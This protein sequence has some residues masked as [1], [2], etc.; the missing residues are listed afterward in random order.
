MKNIGKGR[1]RE[2]VLDMMI[3]GH[4]TSEDQTKGLIEKLIKNEKISDIGG[5]LTV[6]S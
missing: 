3:I 5:Y 1:K 2:E 6:T 4:G